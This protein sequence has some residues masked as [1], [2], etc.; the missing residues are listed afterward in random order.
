MSPFGWWIAVYF[1]LATVAAGSAGA[2]CVLA[3]SRRPDHA[4]AK[5][6][7]VLAIVA[8]GCGALAL[9]ADLERPED[10]WL[11][12]SHY[13]P[14]SWIARGSRIVAAFG[15]LAGALW[16]T[17]WAGA[18][19]RWLLG[20]GVGLALL[21]V[22]L[23][24]YPAF[25]L[26]QEVGRPLWQSALLPPLFVAGAVHVATVVAGVRGRAELAAAAIE[27]ALF[28]AYALQIGLGNLV[29]TTTALVLLVVA[30][31]GLWLVPTVVSLGRSKSGWLPIVSVV[32]GAM[33]ARA[34]ILY[35][36]Q[37]ASL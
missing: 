32:I 25:V 27:L 9:I 6:A 29:P 20:V 36:G 33:A 37:V 8:I 21:A 15:L 16:L 2:A 3:A 22:L 1:G 17:L 28:V 10:F 34:T 12:F 19:R 35:A 24:V 31:V 26:A 18:Q 4:R 11:V 30:F 23:A 14:S 13:N 7:L 5:V